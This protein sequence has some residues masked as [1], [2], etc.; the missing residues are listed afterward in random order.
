MRLSVFL[1]CSLGSEAC[2]RWEVTTVNVSALRDT[3]AFFKRLCTVEEENDEYSV[4]FVA[5][6][7]CFT[8]TAGGGGE[9]K[10]FFRVSDNFSARWAVFLVFCKRLRGGGADGD[11]S[12][13]SVADFS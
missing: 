13:T 7:S 9:P 8:T 6:F 10:R 4:A 1:F 2:E 5:A 3:L 11:G 12:R